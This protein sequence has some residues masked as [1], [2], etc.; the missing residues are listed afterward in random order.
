MEATK[1]S[2]SRSKFLDYQDLGA[3]KYLTI[4]LGLLVQGFVVVASTNS[5]LFAVAAM[6]VSILVL[7]I[8]P[9]LGFFLLALLS[10]VTLVG[11]FILPDFIKKN[12]AGDEHLRGSEVLSSE[13]LAKLIR[14]R[15]Q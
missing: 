9:N 5:Y 7:R 2:E 1:E 10:C 12:P 4:F 6:I 15:D 13:D 3:R 8:F 14:S 11:M